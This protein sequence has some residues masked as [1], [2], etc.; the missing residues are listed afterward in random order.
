MSFA[1]MLMDEPS[2]PVWG[3][4]SGVGVAPAEPQRVTALLRVRVNEIA[5]ICDGQ[6]T[7]CETSA[8]PVAQS[9]VYRSAGPTKFTPR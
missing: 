8:I 4:H 3:C 1:V 9:K 5:P 7:E 2:V 6:R